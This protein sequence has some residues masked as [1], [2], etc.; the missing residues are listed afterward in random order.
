[1]TGLEPTYLT[2]FNGKVLFNGADA[3]YSSFG[4]WVTNGAATGTTEVG[5]LGDAGVTGAY[6]AGLD[7]KY[8]TVFGDK[9]LFNGED[10]DEGG[11]LWITDGTPGGTTE[12]G[13]LND[14]GV[15][16]AFAG[17]LR[18]STITVV[19]SKAFFEGQDSTASQGLWVTDGTP[20]GT[21]EVGG[22]GDAGV[23]DSPGTR[24]LGFGPFNIIAY[25]GEA[26]FSGGDSQLG[27]GLWVT[28]GIAADTTEVGGLNDADVAH[29]GPHGLDPIW[30]TTFDGEMFFNGIDSDRDPTL[31]KSDGTA[32]GTIEIGGL[33][34]AGVAGADA[35]GLN[36]TNF[37]VLGGELLFDGR[38]AAGNYTLWE[39]DGT[40]GGTHEIVAAAVAGVT[41]GPPRDDFEGGDKSDAL[42][43][44]SVGAVVVDQLSGNALSYTQVGGLGMEW[45][46]K[47]NGD[48]L[49][50]GH[51]GFL[52]KNT[53]GTLVVGEVS[54][55]TTTYTQI[56]GVGPEWTFHGT[57][58][59][60]DNGQSQF[61]MENT[62]GVLVVGNV[63]ANVAHYT[64]IGGLGPEWTFEGVG[65]LLGDGQ[66]QFLIKNS[67]GV[68]VVGEVVNGGADYTQ[69]GAVGSEWSF[70]GVGDFLGDGQDQF[71]MENTNGAVVVAEI[72][73][74][75][76]VYTQVSGLGMEWKFVGVG[77]YQGT[78]DTDYM[79]ENSNGVVD[80]GQV[81]HGV[82]SYTQVGG[83]GSEWIFHS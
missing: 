60:L 55:S 18:P 65:D 30:L 36:P 42:M 63:Q 52:I 3:N 28:D 82:A 64:Q 49:G 48:L 7:P 79:I 16:G 27:V 35:A 73:D 47:G 1:L 17:G 33:A 70:K 39:T 19:G 15:T 59:F 12:I 26:Y 32:T 80:I 46:F 83:L 57:G 75:T 71:L 56:G 77:D 43:E 81:S 9:V 72:Q 10:S 8:M 50:D 6:S 23:T 13:G 11:G 4:L 24:G 45:S 31:W 68:L 21:T 29:A 54:G 41:A 14:A 44:N 61:L 2:A 62:N 34:D 58:D 38:D 25:G 20:G 67:N 69:V 78:I 51:E 53:N 66:T 22:L 40:A 76:A 5:G 37:A 74:G